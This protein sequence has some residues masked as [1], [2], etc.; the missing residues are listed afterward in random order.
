[1]VRAEMYEV[2]YMDLA[3]RIGD[4]NLKTGLPAGEE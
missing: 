3:K 1:M 2:I 4:A